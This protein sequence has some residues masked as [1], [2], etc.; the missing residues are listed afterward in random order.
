MFR[1]HENRIMQLISG[2]ATVKNQRLDN[3]SKDIADLKEIL[4]FTQEE[5][6]VKF[7]TLQNIHNGK[8][9]VQPQERHWHQSNY[10]TK[11]GNRYCK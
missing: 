8:K 2:N 9:S 5:T 6:K 11:L 1:S 10:Q 4:E 3:L 7:N